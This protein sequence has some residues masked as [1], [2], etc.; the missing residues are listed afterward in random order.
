MFVV[1]L[2]SSAVQYYSYY[3]HSIPSYTVLR[4]LLLA[5]HYAAAFTVTLGKYGPYIQQ[6]KF[7]GFEGHAT[8]FYRCLIGTVTRH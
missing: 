5:R 2:S 3:S 1:T 7:A 8:S 6:Q 4:Q